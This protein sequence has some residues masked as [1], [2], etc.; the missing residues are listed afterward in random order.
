MT[1]GFSDEDREPRVRWLQIDGRALIEEFDRVLAE[2][3]DRELM[4]LIADGDMEGPAEMPI[5][6]GPWGGYR[7]PTTPPPAHHAALPNT[8]REWKTQV[9]IPIGSPTPVY[10]AFLEMMWRVGKLAPIPANAVW[11]VEVA[12]GYDQLDE[13]LIAQGSTSRAH[14]LRATWPI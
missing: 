7:P 3:M 8:F 6:F 12:P 11:S 5:F 13:V 4:S 10:R 14:I 9:Y 1:V 2:R